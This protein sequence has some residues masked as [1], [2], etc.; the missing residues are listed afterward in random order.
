MIG[1]SLILISISWIALKTQTAKWE[2]AAII[3]IA[4]MGLIL[5]LLELIPWLNTLPDSA[6][7]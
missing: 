3:V 4:A 2:I 5:I 6:G 1:I 7:F